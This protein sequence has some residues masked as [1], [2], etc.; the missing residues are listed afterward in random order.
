MCLANRYGGVG[1]ALNSHV[2]KFNSSLVQASPTIG[3]AGDIFSSMEVSLPIVN[4]SRLPHEVYSYGKIL[5]LCINFGRFLPG[6]EGSV[7]MKRS[8]L[9]ITHLVW[10]LKHTRTSQTGRLSLS[11]LLKIKVL[12]Y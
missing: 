7:K 6:K 11:L 8:K 4:I 5:S 1:K 10:N 2:I 12:C 9:L 3:R